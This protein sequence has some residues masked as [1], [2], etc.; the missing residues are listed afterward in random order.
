MLYQ[1]RECGEQ[2]SSGAT[3]CPYCGAPPRPPLHGRPLTHRL[4]LR[5]ALVVVLA[6][7]VIM[8]PLVLRW[9]NGSWDPCEWRPAHSAPVA[10]LPQDG[11]QAAFVP[12]SGAAES[13]D[14][15]A[16]QCLQA[17]IDQAAL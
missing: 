8:L 16:A 4:A 15:S 12:P 7:P 10:A 3:R 9:H 17:W 2:I 13:A 11:A 6:L 1:C 14:R 5:A